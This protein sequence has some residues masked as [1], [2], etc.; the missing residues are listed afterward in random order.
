MQGHRAVRA[1]RLAAL[2]GWLVLLAGQAAPEK[3][4]LKTYT[5][6][7][8]LAQ[9]NVAR[10]VR[11][12][13]GFLWF[14]T[15]EG[16]SRFDGY[17]FKNY[18]QD[19]GLPHRAV[20]DLL[21][22][23]DG[24]Y[25]L[26]TGGGLVR[27][28][29]Q[30]VSRRWTGKETEA[31]AKD[32]SL[33][34]RV[35]P[36]EDQEPGKWNLVI[37]QLAEDSA[38]K[39]WCAA[40]GGLYTLDRTGGDETLR[41]VARGPWRDGQHEFWA[42]AADNSGAMWVAVMSGIYRLLPD[43]NVQTVITGLG[44]VSLYKDSRGSIWAGRGGFGQAGLHQF[45]C[46]GLEPPRLLRIYDEKDGLVSRFWHYGILETSDGKIWVGS[47]SGVSASTERSADGT[48][49]FRTISNLVVSS[50]GEDSGGNVWIGTES[51]G[52]FRLSR[53]G[54]MSFDERDGLKS[55]R[56]LSIANGIGGEVYF[57]GY[58]NFIHRFDENKF[59]AVSPSGMVKGSWGWNQFHFQDHAGEWWIAGDYGVGLQRY[60]KVSRLEE[61]AHT[62]P[63]RL[64]TV[65]DGLPDNMIFR[66]FEDS[67]GDIWIGTCGP[68]VDRLARWERATDKIYSYTT[69][70]GA[71]PNNGPS[72]FGEDHA[73]NIWVGLYATG[74]ARYRDG[75][76]DW[77]T[78]EDG[79]PAG[80]ISDIYTDSRGRVWVAT[81]TGGVICIDDP[82]AER[83]RLLNLSTA[84]GLSSNYTTC[85]TEDRFGHIYIGTARGV[86]R[87][88]TQSGRIKVF[89]AGD[90]LAENYVNV[91]ECDKSGALWFGFYH[92]VSRFVP[93]ADMQS[94]PPPIFISDVLVNGVAF[95]KLSELGETSVGGLELAADQRQIQ[96]DFFALGFSNG[97]TLRYQYK[98]NDAEWSALAAQRTVNLNLAPG[99][100]QFLVRSVNAEG[101]VSQTPSQ[102]LFSIAR[103]VWQRWWFLALAAALFAAAIYLADRYRVRRLIELERVRTRIATDLHDDIGSNLSLIAMVSEV[104]RHQVNQA[105][106]PVTDQ[107]ALVARTS[108]QSVDAMSDI[109]WAVNPR[110]DH[111]H[112][113]VERMRRFASD[114]FA[115]LDIDFRFAAPSAKLDM[116]LG[117]E[118]RRE[119]YLIFK[120]AVNNLAKHAQCTEAEIDVQV[121]GGQL[122]MVVRDDGKGFD[123]DSANNGYGG[124]GLA[125][126]RE[127]AAV[128]GGRLD[129]ASGAGAG[130][131]VTLRVPLGRRRPRG[132]K[133]NHHGPHR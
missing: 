14:C 104:A 41:R 96:I 7:D 113:L 49:K 120:E 42:I 17:Q 84:E 45:T 125:S 67:R 82:A 126:M 133:N 89:T 39:V 20:Y 6:Y 4:P 19:H 97:E 93:E 22:T 94:A 5:T 63:K 24:Q 43:G 118:F 100:Y 21:E 87:L 88:D 92:G 28:N 11:D 56:G 65:K 111:L 68:S 51:S 37:K 61:L 50:L 122:T 78:E 85:I 23:R 132:A 47:V 80:F 128:L 8:G 131:T 102:V 54:F 26:A 10:I 115:A 40:V 38:G 114:T 83:P 81:S 3:L 66:L 29:P 70:D 119:V 9:D 79:L 52:A 58:K 27:F 91:C 53:S 127:R 12:S 33:M 103:P 55:L 13:R 69:A 2:A 44:F 98:L 16:L 106:S 90:G 86:N 75:R 76:F 71:P 25:W 124:N 73:G 72:A 46:S 105:D 99:A 18:T 30:G 64:Y 95:K 77:F 62:K 60:P 123:P 35:F 109:V 112:D 108:R 1:S 48:V 107:L 110:R 116:K 31:A 57:V 59:T 117:S 129:L 130:T 74:L 101:V 36:P 34:F 121:G 32:Q 15:G